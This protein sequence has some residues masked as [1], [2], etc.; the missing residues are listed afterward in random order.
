VSDHPVHAWP[1]QAVALV[2]WLY[3]LRRF[4]PGWG[5]ALLAGFA[6]GFSYT[7][8]LSLVLEFP[9]LLGTALA[10]YLTLLWMI[11]SV[12][13]AWLL[14]G[15]PVVSAF[16]VAALAVLV[17]WVNSTLIPVWGTAQTFTR[18]WSA[19]PP[20][21]QL[22][23]VT[24]VTGFVFVVVATQALLAVL[25]ARPPRRRA[26][27]IALLSLVG[28]VVAV[29][30]LLWPREARGR[31]R[32]AA[33]GWCHAQQPSGKHTPWRVVYSAVYRPLLREAVAAGAQLVVAPET[34]FRIPAIDREVFL[35]RVR[36]EARSH[37]VWLAV[38]WFDHR[39]RKNRLLFLDPR[40]RTRGQYVKTHLIMTLEKYNAGDGTRVWVPL[41]SV[42]LGGMICQDD[43][44]TDLSRGYGRDAVSVL[45][46]PTN[47][48]EQVAPYHLEN[49]RFRAVESRYAVV[50]AATNGT[51]AILSARGETLA[52]ADHFATGPRAVV[53]DLPLYPPGSFY[54]RWGEWVVWLCGLL[55]LLL[56]VARV[57]LRHRHDEGTI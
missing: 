30:A 1:L 54:A 7:F 14:R 27:L 5:R 52:S 48:W 40:G 23:S 21:I 17:E 22:V 2:P 29:N 19:W 46:V 11:L 25:L 18:V 3:A 34:A 44:F 6:L 8:A 56:L 31:M 38:G 41:G 55:L 36:R 20:A 43:N 39:D 51:S 53:A 35:A 33:V 26:V 12:G 49:S 32:V 50:R 24:G 57:T 4:R 13:A 9:L 37:G 45:A 42:R 47:D 16:A 15:P 10:L 28:L